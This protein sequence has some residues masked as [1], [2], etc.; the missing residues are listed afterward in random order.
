MKPNEWG[1]YVWYVIHIIF[2]NIPDDDY[3]ITNRNVYLTFIKSLNSII[4]CPICRSHFHN[5]LKK[6][7]L[8]RCNTK[9]DIINWSID[10]HNLVNTRLNNK[11]FLRKDC[12]I[13]YQ[14]IDISYFFH[15]IDILTYN[16]QAKI[17]IKQYKMMFNSFKVILPGNELKR[18]Y[19]KSVGKY[20]I[21]F[22]TYNDILIWYRKVGQYI[23][24]QFK[25]NSIQN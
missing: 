5:L 11:S 24:K 14:N 6:D 4:P 2:Y 20:K 16:H 15:G 23:L 25:S 3:F 1:P 8:K 12:D 9:E 18:Y 10:K 21:D 13:I 17:P 19:N 22:N 7:D